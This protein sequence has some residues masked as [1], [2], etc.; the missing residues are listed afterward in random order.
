M[1]SGARAQGKPAR[2]WSDDISDWCS[3]CSLPDA[4]HLMSNRVRW[5]EMINEVTEL[6]TSW[7]LWWVRKKKKNILK[8]KKK[9]KKKN[10]KKKSYKEEKEEQ[11]EQEQEQEEWLFMHGTQ[12]NGKCLTDDDNGHDDDDYGCN[13]YEE[14]AEADKAVNCREINY[15]FWRRWWWWRRWWRTNKTFTVLVRIIASAS[16]FSP[17]TVHVRF[18]VLNLAFILQTVVPWRF[19]LKQRTIRQANCILIKIHIPYTFRDLK[20]YTI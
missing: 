14:Y 8:K 20:C 5:N 13:D 16:S 12:T 7:G 18:L 4:V 11:E 15:W 3:C 6:N 19:Q 9:K 2:W 17:R 10:K 1:F